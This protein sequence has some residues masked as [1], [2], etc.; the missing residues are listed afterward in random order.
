MQAQRYFRV[1]ETGSLADVG[2]ERAVQQD[3]LGYVI[4]PDRS[5]TRS[6]AWRKGH[7]Y[8]LADGVGGSQSGEIA[9]RLAVETVIEDFYCSQDLE[10]ETGLKKTI[11]SAH[12]R[13]CTEGQRRQLA[14]MQTTVVCAAIVGE[15]VYVAHVGDSRAYL[16]RS[17]AIVART[18]DHA[19]G[20]SL[21]T[22]SLGGSHDAAPDVAQY[23]IAD[24]D[25]LILCSDGLHGELDDA[26]IVQTVTN[27]ASPQAA[28]NALVDQAKAK[29]GK[30]NISVIVVKIGAAKPAPESIEQT[31]RPPRPNQIRKLRRIV[32]GASADAQRRT[33]YWEIGKIALAIILVTVALLSLGDTLW[34]R[35]QNRALRSEI[36]ALHQTIW[37]IQQDVDMLNEDYETGLYGPIDPK[38]AAKLQALQLQVQAIVD[39]QQSSPPLVI[40]TPTP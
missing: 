35:Q 22:R 5:D 9:S 11:T 30:D 1:V 17:G 25:F 10:I 19:E 24:G 27:A 38:L 2:R 7:L 37:T 3:S 31:F 18:V 39:P 16:L 12:D 36:D 26:T 8:V 33:G 40:P 21:I 13:I 34:V 6:L 23:E 28:C 29:G 15:Y 14:K 4:I 20:R 32:S